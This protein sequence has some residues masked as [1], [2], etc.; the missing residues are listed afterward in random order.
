MYKLKRNIFQDLGGSNIIP[1]P[2]RN[3][4]TKLFINKTGTP[5]MCV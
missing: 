2:E 3:Y 5:T 4:N 1:E